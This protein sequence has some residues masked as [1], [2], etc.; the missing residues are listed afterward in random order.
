MTHSP[1]EALRAIVAGGT[2]KTLAKVAPLGSLQARKQRDGVVVFAWRF[3]V[4]VGGVERESREVIGRYDAAL[5]PKSLKP[6]GDRYSVAAAIRA[7]EA[8]AEAHVAKREEGGM[9]AIR[10]EGARARLEAEAVAKTDKAMTLEA[11]LTDYAEHLKAQ[12]KDAFR[13]VR[14][15]TNTHVKGTL[16]ARKAARSI[17]PEDVAD[18]Q[19][20]IHAS[21]KTRTANKARSYIRAAYE[22]AKTAR[23][24]ASVPASFKGYNVTTNPAADTKVVK[25]GKRPVIRALTLAQFRAY[26]QIVRKVEGFRGAMLRFHLFT[27]GQRLDQLVRLKPEDIHADYFTIYDPKGKPGEGPRPHVVP[28]IPAARE[29]LAECAARKGEWAFTTDGGATH[30][31]GETLSGWSID[32]VAGAIPGFAPKLIRSGVET[33]LAASG[34]DKETR[35]RL[36]SHGISGV[37][38]R[39]Y[40][41]HEFM[42]EKRA[43]LEL[44]HKLLTAR[45]NASKVVPINHRRAA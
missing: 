10:A 39:H 35:G 23:V 21:G 22:L 11:L 17:T 18:V 44:V 38:D 33:I 26:W 41:A 31:N 28:L 45:G 8:L 16:A 43:A 13:D 24:D 12:G 29:A 5:P 25:T 7:A 36:Q 34:V 14:S 37:Q 20:R 1:A 19:R 40:N 3:S 15:I 32:E 27:G 9:L 42:A 30:V 4:T 2:F 6:T